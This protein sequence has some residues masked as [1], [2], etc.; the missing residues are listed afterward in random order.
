MVTQISGAIGDDVRH[1]AGAVGGRA[2]RT[3]N[4]QMHDNENEQ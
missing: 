2:G 4:V 1:N 3:K